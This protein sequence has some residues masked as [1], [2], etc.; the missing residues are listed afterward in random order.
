M[1][2][3]S[4][5]LGPDAFANVALQASNVTYILF[6]VFADSRES[7]TIV[8]HSIYVKLDTF[9]E[10]PVNFCKFNTKKQEKQTYQAQPSKDT[11]R[12]LCK[13]TVCPFI[14]DLILEKPKQNSS[15]V[16]I[17]PLLRAMFYTFFNF[18]CRCHNACGVLISLLLF[19][20]TLKQCRTLK[21]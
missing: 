1:I 8:F 13:I 18:L 21:E 16:P 17:S 6:C 19:Q 7:T 4:C 15:S 3:C 14:Y 12:P 9:S 11:L 10:L 20:R 2:L 5:D